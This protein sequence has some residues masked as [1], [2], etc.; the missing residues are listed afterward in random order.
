MGYIDFWVKFFRIV[1]SSAMLETASIVP[2]KSA[3]KVTTF[4]VFVATNVHAPNDVKILFVSGFGITYSFVS[5]SSALAAPMSAGVVGMSSSRA[6]FLFSPSSVKFIYYIICIS[7]GVIH[8]N[9]PYLIANII[10]RSRKNK[11][12]AWATT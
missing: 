5:K 7:I 4:P 1:R 6:I 9:Q 10:I 12:I 3:F 11:C 2:D 8:R